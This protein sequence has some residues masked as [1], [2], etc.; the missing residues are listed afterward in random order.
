MAKNNK[1]IEYT[2]IFLQPLDYILLVIDMYYFKVTT[3][4]IFSE[5]LC[6]QLCLSFASGCFFNFMDLFFLEFCV[7]VTLRFESRA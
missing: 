7:C 4:S 2:I 5:W 6:Y 1:M 3:V